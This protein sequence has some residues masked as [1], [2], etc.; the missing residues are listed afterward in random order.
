MA[1]T[2]HSTATCLAITR[3]YK[4]G[5]GYQG[6]ASRQDWN[7]DIPEMQIGGEYKDAL[8]E[9]GIWTMGL[10][11]FGET[12]PYHENKVTLDKSTRKT[13]GVLNVLSFD[14]E[15]KE[16]EMKMRKDIKDDA[17]EMLTS[18]GVK[19]VKGYDHDAVPRPWYSRN[20][21]CP[22]G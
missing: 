11:G 12:L 10:G 18:M 21:N 17:M 9:P 2:F 3:D 20:G 5:F 22:H 6:G 15:L 16:N 8:T 7:R 13:N 1:Y 4:R 14:V 19:D